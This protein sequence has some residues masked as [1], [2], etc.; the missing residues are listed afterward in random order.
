MSAQ[1]MAPMD[2]EMVMNEQP[3]TEEYSPIYENGFMDPVNTPLSTFSIDVDN[4]AYSNVRRFLTENE[5][6]PPKNAVRIEEM[7]NYFDYDYPEPKGEDPFCVVAEVSGCPWN[8]EHRLVHIGIQGKSMDNNDVK[9][10]NYVFLI[11][12][13]GSM[14][15]ANKLPLVKRS[16]NVLLNNLGDK[17]RIALVTYA[18]NAGLVLESTKCSNRKK[19]E[20]AIDR[21]EAGGATAGGDGLQLAYNVAKEAYIEGGNNRV[22]LCTDGDFNVGV[23]STEELVN[24]IE[25]KRKSDIY[26]TICGFGMNNYKDDKMEGISNAGNGNYFYIDNMQEANKVFGKEMRANMF[27]IAKDVKVQMEFNPAVVSSYRLIGYEDRVLNKEDFNDDTKDAGELG[28]GHTVTALYEVVPGSSKGRPKVDPL[29]YQANNTGSSTGEMMT[30]KLR[31]KPIHSE[32]SKKIE[33]IVN[34]H[35]RTL[36]QSSDDFRF[37]AAVAGFGMLLRDSEYKG[38]L[39]Y[40]D[41]FKLAKSTDGY[42]RDKYRV[43]FLSLVSKAMQLSGKEYE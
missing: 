10:G 8:N 24:M 33:M 29:K 37:S 38:D 27:T 7:I 1:D 23:S 28:A 16:L 30:V 12:V 40:A 25:E 31:Y 36:E 2:K 41:V 13:S 6:L 11:D 19:I 15:A 34:D 18:G 20:K 39:T 35:G 4:A 26:L 17:D 3:G 42:N 22:I 21:L 43:E 32:D 9:A 5:M 14:D